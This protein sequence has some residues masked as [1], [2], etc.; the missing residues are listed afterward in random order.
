MRILFIIPEEFG[1]KRWGGVTT[2]TV[3]MATELHHRGHDVSILTPGR[4][5]ESFAYQGLRIH[6]VSHGILHSPSVSVLIKI[7]RRVIPDIIERLL[8]AADVAQFVRKTDCFDVIEAPEW[9]SS[10]LFL[11]GKASARVVVRL[12]KSWLMYKADNRLPISLSDR[13]TD[14]FER[15]CILTASI[16]TSPTHFMLR[17]YPWIMSF[18][19]RKKTPTAVIPYGITLPPLRMPPALFEF[20][21]YIL[22]VGRIEVAKGSVSLSRAFVRMSARYPGMHLVFVGEDTRMFIGDTWTSCISYI[23]SIVPGSVRAR[24][25]F[26]SRKTRKELQ[27]YYHNCLL[28]VAP[29]YGHENPS[30]ALLEAIAHGKASV[31]SRVGGIPE[32]LQSRQNGLIFSEGDENDLVKQIQHLVDNAVFRTRCEMNARVL[33]KQYDIRSIARKTEAWYES[34]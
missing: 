25:H 6:K 18:L 20:Q 26:I 9:G 2:Y 11:S 13:L 3:E 31:G 28:Y 27:R 30:I 34:R 29:S 10:T 5:D 24:V 23:R 4:K 33:R 15:W 21:P 32:I 1:G 7:F 22:C 19:E 17:Q 16:V 14:L 8:W 12:H